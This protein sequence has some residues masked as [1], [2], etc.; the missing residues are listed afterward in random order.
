LKKMGGSFDFG[1]HSIFPEP[2]Q[3]TWSLCHNWA[4]H[5]SIG[6]MPY[7]SL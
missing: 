1:R 6:H 4:I 3:G 2:I 7:C 5:V